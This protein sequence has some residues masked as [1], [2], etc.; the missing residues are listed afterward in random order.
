MGATTPRG[1]S[2]VGMVPVPEEAGL[3]GPGVV[4]LAGLPGAGKST[5]ARA[6][7]SQVDGVRVIDKDEVR[8]GLF[9]PCDYAPEEGQVAFAAM[10]A[11]AAYHLRRGRV[12]VFDGLTFARSSQVDA[13]LGAAREAGGFTAVLS[14][15]VPVAV[16]IARVEADEGHRAANRDAA[17][18]RRV[19]AELEDLPEPHLVLDMNRPPEEVVA[20]A[21][22]Y[23]R[24][25]SRPK[26]H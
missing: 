25:R 20:E 16:A 13:A 19:A 17:L 10:V 15:S 14:C 8:H 26:A 2:V 6:L 4:V 24:D 21:L 1:R 23:L 11:G 12:V 7:A 22:A 9:A 3:V 5:L 18:V